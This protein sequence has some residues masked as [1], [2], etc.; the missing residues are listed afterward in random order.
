PA[1]PPV[2]AGDEHLAV[3]T[4]D[5][6]GGRRPPAAA[7]DNPGAKPVR[8]RAALADGEI[9]RMGSVAEGSIFIHPESTNLHAANDNFGRLL[10]ADPSR[11]VAIY[12]NPGTGE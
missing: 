5:E 2:A 10:N 9:L 7:N 6:E 12:Y 4:A 11:E 3:R 1:A 8:A